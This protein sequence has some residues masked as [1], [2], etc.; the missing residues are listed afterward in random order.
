MVSVLHLQNQHVMIKH[1]K[2]A[3]DSI[4]YMSQNKGSGHSS[5]DL[6]YPMCLIWQMELTCLKWKLATLNA[7]LTSIPYRCQAITIFSTLAPE[8]HSQEIGKKNNPLAPRG[9]SFMN[10]KE[11]SRE[12]IIVRYT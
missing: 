7:T 1:P 4:M 6:L 9:T 2:V 10:L 5:I 12:F 8:V 3:L 11:R